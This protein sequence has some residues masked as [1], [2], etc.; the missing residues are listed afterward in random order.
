MYNLSFPK[1]SLFEYLPT[2]YMATCEQQRNRREVYNFKDG[3]CSDRVYNGLKSQILAIA[4]GCSSEWVIAFIPASTASRARLKYHSLARRLAE[5]LS[6][7]VCEDA[8]VNSCDRE[9]TM[10]TGKVSDP[11]STFSISPSRICG[12]KVI[13]I[14]DVITTGSS[15]RH[16]ANRLVSCGATAVHG[17]F[18]AQTINP[19]WN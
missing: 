7:E 9:S 16:C 13:L 12:K 3:Y 6:I 8:I 19:D 14:D 1:T 18:V 11:T 2:R 15:F 10:V 4:G 5:D 17:L